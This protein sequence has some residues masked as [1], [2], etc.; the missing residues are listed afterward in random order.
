MSDNKLPIYAVVSDN[1][2]G[3]MKVLIGLATVKNGTVCFN[4]DDIHP[5]I[6]FTNSLDEQEQKNN[7]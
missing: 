6:V 4:V 5:A 2:N 7:G 1:N 3:E